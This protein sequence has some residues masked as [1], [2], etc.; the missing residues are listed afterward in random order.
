M[1][2]EKNQIITTM[3]T[4]QHTIPEFD[5]FGSQ[6]DHYLLTNYG[7]TSEE[8]RQTIEFDGRSG[9]LA[10]MLDETPNPQTGKVC[11]IGSMFRKA[12][13]E[14]GVA[15]VQKSFEGLKMMNAKTEAVISDKNELDYLLA[16]ATVPEKADS[17]KKVM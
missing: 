12:H 2:P 16:G 10:Q 15:A 9:T 3:E 5:E 17:K 4:G 8:G 7:I 14:G 13:A 1:G 6:P 11:P